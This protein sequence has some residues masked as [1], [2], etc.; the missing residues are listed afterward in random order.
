MEHDLDDVFERIRFNFNNVA[1]IKD[2]KSRDALRKVVNDEQRTMLD[3]VK[4]LLVAS[5]AIKE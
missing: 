2:I 4:P 5:G 3:E 1:S